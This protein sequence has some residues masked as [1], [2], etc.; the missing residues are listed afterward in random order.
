MKRKHGILI[1]AHQTAAAGRL[2]AK[3]SIERERAMSAKRNLA[4]PLKPCPYLLTSSCIYD[5]LL[6]Y[7]SLSFPGIQR[8]RAASQYACQQEWN[9]DEDDVLSVR[10]FNAVEKFK[11]DKFNYDHGLVYEMNG[12]GM[13]T[14]PG[15]SKLM[16]NIVFYCRFY[17][18]LRPGAWSDTASGVSKCTRSWNEVSIKQLKK[19][20]SILLM[21]SLFI[22]HLFSLSLSLPPSLSHRIPQDDFTVQDVKRL[23][24]PRRVVDVM[25]TRTQEASTMTLS[26]WAKY[27]DS[28]PRHKLLNVISLEFSCTKLDPLVMPPTMV[29]VY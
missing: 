2:Y 29:R 4:S 6:L 7:F 17:P 25:D 11:E 10:R 12:D 24:G 9:L 16:N 13:K 15:Q 23:V 19:H 18:E 3:S 20:L 22:S 5:I 28:K 8:P 1:A 26:Q 27:Y 14:F 21:H